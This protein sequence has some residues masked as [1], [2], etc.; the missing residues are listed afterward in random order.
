MRGLPPS[1]RRARQQKRRGEVSAYLVEIMQHRHDGSSF[2]LPASQ[3]MQ[4][5][6]GRALVEASEGLIEQNDVGVLQKQ[7]CK[8]S[9]LELA[10]GKFGDLPIYDARE[11]D[12]RECLINTRGEAFRRLA[13]R[14]EISPIAECHQFGDRDRKPAVEFV[15]LRQIRQAMA[16]NSGASD[17]AGGRPND[18]GKRFQ[19]RALPGSIGADDGREARGR[20]LTGQAFKRVSLAIANGEIADRDPFLPAATV[21]VGCARIVTAIETTDEGSLR[22]ISESRERNDE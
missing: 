1:D 22:V 10:D 14:T 3:E 16:R 21:P 2:S 19:E 6:L 5:I 4:Q 8:Q 9:P 15:L 13:D 20:E 11:A 12:G 7:P 17:L 18:P